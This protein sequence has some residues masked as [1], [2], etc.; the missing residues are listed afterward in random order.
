[1][2]TG[3]EKLYSSICSS[4]VRRSIWGRF[5]AELTIHKEMIDAVTGDLI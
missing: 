2:N 3:C 5:G 1:M 4:P